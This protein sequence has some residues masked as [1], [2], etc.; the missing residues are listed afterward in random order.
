MC[1]QTGIW[2]RARPPRVKVSWSVMKAIKKT[3]CVQLGESVSQH[4]AILRC[5]PADE[6]KHTLCVGSGLPIESRSISVLLTMTVNPFSILSLSPVWFLSQLT[7]ADQSA[8]GYARMLHSIW[9]R[10]K[11]SS[12]SSQLRLRMWFRAF[13]SFVFS[14][15]SSRV[16]DSQQLIWQGN[17]TTVR[18]KGDDGTVAHILTQGSEIRKRICDEKSRD[19]VSNTDVGL[20]WILLA[21]KPI[22]FNVELELFLKAS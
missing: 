13:S 10:G 8:A 21:Q 16:L 19:Y 4:S 5:C 6:I 11:V 2:P 15:L 20:E 14:K 7:P 17:M 12:C 18:L 3:V 1:K 22:Q 9:I